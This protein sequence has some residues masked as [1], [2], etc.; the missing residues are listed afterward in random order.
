MCD[1]DA[2]VASRAWNIGKLGPQVPDQAKMQGVWMIQKR[3]IDKA[4]YLVQSTCSGARVQG[5][6]SIAGR[7]PSRRLG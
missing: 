1:L 2:G 3:I 5:G 6:Q 4:A 7:F